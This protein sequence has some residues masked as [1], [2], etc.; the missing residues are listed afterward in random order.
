MVP[1]FRH[2]EKDDK[3]PNK[4]AELTDV[5]MIKLDN[6]DIR[7]QS[8]LIT[9]GE[10]VASGNTNY[11]IPPNGS[12]AD[13]QTVESSF[14]DRLSSEVD[15][16]LATGETRVRDAILVA[17]DNLVISMVNPSIKSVHASSGRDPRSVALDSD[18]IILSGN[19]E[20]LHM[21]A[22]SSLNSNTDLDRIDV[23]HV[24]I[25]V[26]A[27]YLQSVKKTLTDKHSHH[28]TLTMY[29]LICLRLYR[30]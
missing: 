25:T 16:A 7:T 11:L 18:Q 24:N 5:L 29:N 21:T 30:K 3:N 4:L 10:N 14:T 9:L 12:Q 17:K 1:W 6:R 27:G 26:E 23:T 19:V 2:R 20:S 13:M 28:K 15:N 8:R 22:S